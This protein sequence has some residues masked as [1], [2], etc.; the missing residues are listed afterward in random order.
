MRKEGEEIHVET[1]EVRGGSSS[2]VVRWVLLIGLLI[3]IVALSI[4]WMTGAASSSGDEPE[5][6]VSSTDAPAE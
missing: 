6:S 2:G 1:D 5:P 4:T 3:A